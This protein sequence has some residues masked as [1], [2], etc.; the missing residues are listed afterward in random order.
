MPKSQRRDNINFRHSSQDFKGAR[1]ASVWA[2]INRNL[3]YRLFQVSKN[4]FQ[5]GK[6]KWQEQKAQEESGT[7]KY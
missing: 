4:L 6:Q 7:K 3:P 5:K 1:A 2:K